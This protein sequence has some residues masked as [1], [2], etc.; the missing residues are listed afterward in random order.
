MSQNKEICKN[1]NWF[2]DGGCYKD[3]RAE[4]KSPEDF[5]SYWTPK[6]LNETLCSKG[7]FLED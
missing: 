3:P 1:C 7:V 4:I 2:K 6:M 5:C